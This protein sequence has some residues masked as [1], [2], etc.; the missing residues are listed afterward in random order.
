MAAREMGQLSLIDAL[1]LVLRTKWKP[2]V[3]PG[4]SPLA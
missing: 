2:E 1:A 4:G 3:R